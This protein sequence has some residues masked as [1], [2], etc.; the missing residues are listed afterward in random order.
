MG[1]AFWVAVILGVVLWL[2]RRVSGVRSTPRATSKA[3]PTA[4]PNA[5]T[6]VSRT[7]VQARTRPIPVPSNPTPPP[8]TS[9]VSVPIRGPEPPPITRIPSI[10]PPPPVRWI[11]EDVVV[12]VGG[13]DIRGGLIYAGSSASNPD[14]RDEPSVID[15][16]LP[17]APSASFSQWTAS[18]W[19]QYRTCSSVDRRLLVSWL[20]NGRK[21]PQAPI[22]LVFL[23]FYGLER[24]LLHDAQ[25]DDTARREVPRLIAEIDRLRRIY[26]NAS[27]Q[28]YAGALRDLA[29]AVY[30]DPSRVRDFTGCRAGN[31]PA[32]L[33]IALG[34]QLAANKPLSPALAYA[35]ARCGES[36]PRP[37]STA[38]VADELRALFEIRYTQRFGAGLVVARPKRALVVEYHGAASN[39][40]QMRL[41]IDLPDVRALSAPQRP[42]AALLDGCATDL[43]HLAKARR[44][45]NVEPLECAAALPSELQASTGLS[46][47]ATL[48][49]FVDRV[50]PAGK[51]G[52]TAVDDLLQ[53]AAFRSDKLRKRECVVVASALESLGYGMEPDVRWLGPSLSRGGRMALYRCGDKPAQAPTP[54]YRIAQ[55]FLQMTVAVAS[56]DGAVDDVELD[57]AREHINAMAGLDPSERGRLHAHLVWLTVAKPSFAKLAAQLKALEPEQRRTLADAAVGVAAADGRIDPGEIRTLEKIYRALAMPVAEVAG[58]V[59]RALTGS[60]SRRTTPTGLDTDALARKIEETAD[61]QKL[62]TSIFADAD[63]SAIPPMSEIRVADPPSSPVKPEDGAMEGLD[64]PEVVLLKRLLDETVE[65]V[66][67]ARIDAWCRELGLMPDGALESLNEVAFNVAGDA[68]FDAEDD[69]V[70]H[71]DIREHLKTLFQGATA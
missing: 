1:P 4:I 55:L 24:R 58:D 34:R 7:S 14:Y 6:V 29:I 61:V 50:A 26:E 47:L 32:G 27:F 52:I 5:R 56:A 11:S 42:L 46:E 23:Y 60:G 64:G 57:H 21:D 3:A 62:L 49:A 65:V 41:D 15:P 39:R 63:E 67:R 13:T 31:I 43:E 28:G 71:A 18:Y 9:P 12:T 30:G 37:Y 45:P 22:G 69:I 70:I 20:A 17:L 38:V 68:L 44:R 10:P 16:T 19:P 66:S 2:M 54:N 25:A 51:V 59:H 33:L 35:W 53:A 36:A 40:T 8:A 48:R